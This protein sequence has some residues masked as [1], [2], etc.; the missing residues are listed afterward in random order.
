MHGTRLTTSRDPAD[1]SGQAYFT[2][3]YFNVLLTLII[4]GSIG[5]VLS[6]RVR[7]R[8]FPP[9]PMSLVDWR[10]G[11]L[12]KPAAG[13]LGSPDSA[14]GAP[15]TFRG[16]AIEKEAE[17]FAT[18]VA[19]I[20]VS[21]WTAQ[22]QDTKP[23]NQ[24]PD[25]EPAGSLPRPQEPTTL[26]A[27]AMDK[28]NGVEDSSNDKT[29]GPMQKAIWSGVLPCLHILYAVSDTWERLAKCVLH[30]MSHYF[31]LTYIAVL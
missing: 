26:M 18:T 31:M 10:T 27:I 24:D 14:T 3:W 22:D 17:S 29:K 19:G 4:C 23:S 9:V 16:E 11:G 15:E 25:A 8:L 30:L 2:G 28:V 20:A 6:E 7:T 12:S 5:M 21:V 13:V 1:L